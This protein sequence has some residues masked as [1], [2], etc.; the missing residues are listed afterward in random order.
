MAGLSY[1]LRA[2]DLLPIA[3]CKPR[4]LG[5]DGKFEVKAWMPD[6]RIA[7][8]CTSAAHR[9]CVEFCI[10][11][12]FLKDFA[13]LAAWSLPHARELTKSG[14]CYL[15]LRGKLLQYRGP[16][17][18]KTLA[19]HDNHQPRLDQKLYDVLPDRGD[20]RDRIWVPYVRKSVCTVGFVLRSGVTGNTYRERPIYG[21]YSCFVI[22]NDSADDTKRLSCSHWK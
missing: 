22:Q 12:E 4:S 21:I 2:Y 17:F 10:S 13:P 15:S 1:N 8:T 9:E 3:S 18:G 14:Y 7:T 20:G 5:D 6:W 19:E 16:D 11:R